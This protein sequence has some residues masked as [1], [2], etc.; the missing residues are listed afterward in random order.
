M[1]KEINNNFDN[2][3]LLS[4]GFVMIK[5]AYENQNNFFLLK[6]EDLNNIIKEKDKKILEL[7][8]KIESLKELNYE[9]KTDLINLKKENKQLEN[10][11]NEFE[12]ENKNNNNTINNKI[13]EKPHLNF[14]DNININVNN[15][16]NTLNDSI[17]KIQ[18]KNNKTFN[19]EPLK[20]FDYSKIYE[21][22]SELTEEKKDNIKTKHKLLKEGSKEFFN[23]SRRTMNKE[24]Y[25]QL[26]NIIKLSNNQQIS[27]NDT[28]LRITNLLENN[29]PQLEWTFKN[30]FNPLETEEN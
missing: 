5:Q 14:N 2:S 15:I 30:L 27:K 28:Y 22:L 12:E 1:N 7:E 6:F 16:I 8:N 19:L 24:D 20:K 10:K 21:N 25:A 11:L 23:N 29:Y 26:M 17:D 3:N 9:L 4:N 18:Q 13:Y